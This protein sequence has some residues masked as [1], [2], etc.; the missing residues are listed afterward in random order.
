MSLLIHNGWQ[1]DVAVQNSLTYEDI[2]KK[3]TLPQVKN[4]LQSL[5]VAEIEE[6]DD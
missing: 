6:H 4:F 2:I 3:I 1:D 5:G